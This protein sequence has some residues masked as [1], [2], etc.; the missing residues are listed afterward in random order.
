MDTPILNGK[1]KKSVI[2]QYIGSNGPP[3][4]LCARAGGR[5]AGQCGRLL[6]RV[7]E[8]T[9]AFGWFSWLNWVGRSHWAEAARFPVQ[10]PPVSIRPGGVSGWPERP[11]ISQ[12]HKSSYAFTVRPPIYFSFSQNG[13][14]SVCYVIVI[15]ISLLKSIYFRYY[16]IYQLFLFMISENGFSLWERA[17]Q[18]PN[19]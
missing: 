17:R 6:T 5:P 13:Q 9:I 18:G 8:P 19:I 7:A 16:G 2:L 3:Q 12:H 15:F 14:K 11:S 1:Y 10:N 4:Y